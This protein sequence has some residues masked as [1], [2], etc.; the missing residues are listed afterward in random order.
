MDDNLGSPQMVL[1]VGGVVRKGY[2]VLG[3]VVCQFVVAHCVLS[4]EATRLFIYRRCESKILGRRRKQGLKFLKRK[5]C[6]IFILFRF[7][8]GYIEYNHIREA[9]RWKRSELSCFHGLIEHD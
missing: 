8:R 7:G 6:R 3:E 4:G 5:K 9:E 2:N 1:M